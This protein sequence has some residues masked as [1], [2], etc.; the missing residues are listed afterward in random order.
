MKNITIKQSKELDQ[1]IALYNEKD[2]AHNI[3]CRMSIISTIVDETFMTGM[4]LSYI[5]EQDDLFNIESATIRCLGYL[6]EGVVDLFSSLEIFGKFDC[7]ECGR[8]CEATDNNGHDSLNNLI[9]PAEFECPECD[10]FLK[11]TE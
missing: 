11:A 1:L 7:P 2:L 4:K 9:Y 6:Q 5:I 3:L 8:E 10:K